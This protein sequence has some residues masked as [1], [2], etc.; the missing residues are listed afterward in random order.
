MPKAASTHI[1]LAAL[2]NS[3][4]EHLSVMARQ[5]EAEGFEVCWLD[6]GHEP[7]IA[8]AVKKYSGRE[9]VAVHDKRA[10]TRHFRKHRP[11]A[12]WL[13]TPYEEHYPAFFWEAVERWPLA[14]APYASGFP[15]GSW[16]H[17]Q[18]GLDTFKK[19]EW[20]LIT[21]ESMGEGYIRHGVNPQR[22]L[23]TGGPMMYEIQ[24]PL[25]AP[26]ERNDIL[27]APHWIEDYFGLGSFTTWRWVAPVL[28]AHATAHPEISIVVRPHPFLAK[29]IEGA[30]ADDVDANTYRALL[31]LPNVRE[32]DRS[33]VDDVLSSDA[34]L[35]E[36][37]S[38]NV[39]FATTGKPLG[40][41]RGTVREITD[42]W[43]FMLDISDE[44]DS[45]E[46]TK[47]WLESLP[48]A[49]LSATRQ[50]AIG[51]VLP[52]FDRS[53]MAIWKDALGA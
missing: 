41:T 50:S 40:M 38:L 51:T 36:G 30:A 42:E 46:D 4:I 14:Y 47:A 34:L 15:G 32:S 5:A 24:H 27:W 18:F 9:A 48:K 23:F 37:M 2:S 16:E 3:T 44:L 35:S 19:C 7:G 49:G 13:H 52:T 33:L 31:T 45:P 20:L 39:Y 6:L 22:I 21:H 43:Q 28:L 17:G 1:C 29:A 10:L 12:V 25:D 53:P 8:G 11:R 26:R